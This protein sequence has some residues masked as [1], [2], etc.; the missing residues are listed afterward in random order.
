[1]VKRGKTAESVKKKDKECFYLK[2]RLIVLSL[3]IC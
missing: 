3:L 1:M 2:K